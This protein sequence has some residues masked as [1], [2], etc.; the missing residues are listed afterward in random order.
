MCKESQVVTAVAP[1]VPSGE[2]IEEYLGDRIQKRIEKYAAGL[3]ETKLAELQAVPD[4]DK[5]A[6]VGNRLAADRNGHMSEEAVAFQALRCLRRLHLSAEQGQFGDTSSIYM[7]DGD[8]F[9][10]FVDRKIHMEIG[11]FVRSESGLSIPAYDSL[12]DNTR[13]RLCV[14]GSYAVERMAQPQLFAVNYFAERIAE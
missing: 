11:L 9:W 3:D 4:N 6:Y 8:R 2:C 10:H 13:T 14:I 1:H 12:E 5:R 7:P